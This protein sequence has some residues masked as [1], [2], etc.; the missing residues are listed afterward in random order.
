MN[1]NTKKIFIDCGTN[2]GDGLAHFHKRYNFSPQWEIYTFEPNPY[3]K[4]YIEQNIVGKNPQ[5]PIHF[6]DMA[7]CGN[8]APETMEFMMQK[9]PEHEKPIGGGSTLL[10]HDEFKQEELAGY[11]KV[12]VKTAR[13]SN[14]IKNI[15]TPYAH[16][17][18]GAMCFN[19]S[20]CMIVV[21]LDVE[22]AEYD[23]MQDLLDTGAAWAITDLHVEFH[24]RRFKESKK[25]EEVRLVGELFQRGINLFSH[26]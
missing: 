1:L 13:L 10:G 17:E 11:E 20:K 8:N 26:Y 19:K 5:I 22:G 15:A 23:I 9:V 6:F 7:L 18:N 2:L 12:T 24:S 16:V 4:D 25:E 3:L 14:I 21:K